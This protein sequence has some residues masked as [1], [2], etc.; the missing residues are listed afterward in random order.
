MGVLLRTRAVKPCSV[1]VCVAK[2]VW[3]C[4]VVIG[5]STGKQ[6]FIFVCVAERAVPL[7]VNCCIKLLMCAVTFVFLCSTCH[8]GCARCAEW[9]C[10]NY[11]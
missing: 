2:M 8:P 7:L 4:L 10:G 1:F 3:P 5:S 6:G 11:R 9:C